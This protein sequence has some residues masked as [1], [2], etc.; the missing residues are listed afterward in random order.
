MTSSEGIPA[1]KNLAYSVRNAA[2]AYLNADYTSVKKRRRRRNQ[3]KNMTL[4]IQARPLQTT[5]K[6][7]QID[8]RHLTKEYTSR[9]DQQISS[10]IFDPDVIKPE[11]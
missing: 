3:G 2:A 11:K 8:L 10:T 1:P 6:S 5:A 4:S 9:R 7:K